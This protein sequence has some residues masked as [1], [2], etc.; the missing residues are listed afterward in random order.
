MKGKQYK[1]KLDPASASRG[2]ELAN[3]NANSLLNDAQLLFENDRFERSLALSILSIEESGKASIIRSILLTDDHKELKTEWQNYR[4]H[5]QKNVAWILPELVKA[6]TR[7]LDELRP[8]VDMDSDHPRILDDLKQLAF[9]TDI[10][11]ARKWIIPSKVVDKALANTFLNI[12][13]VLCKKEGG[14]MTSEQEL[15]LWIKH[16]KPVWKKD[17]LSMK[18][19]LINCYNEAESLGLMSEGETKKMIDFLI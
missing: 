6:G 7:Q 11:S 9:Y 18:Q 13:K 8:I 10:F 14:V 19:A 16:V 4:R 1:G 15:E 12:A 3:L 2:I 17:M 5:T